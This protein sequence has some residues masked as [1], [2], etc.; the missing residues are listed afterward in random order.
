MEESDVKRAP[1]TS[2]CIT[3]LFSGGHMHLSR[4]IRRVPF[5][6]PEQ[7]EY[8]RVSEPTIYFHITSFRWSSCS[9]HVPVEGKR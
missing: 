6:Q 4:R 3:H 8:T 7:A 5:R 9:P 2:V 1:M